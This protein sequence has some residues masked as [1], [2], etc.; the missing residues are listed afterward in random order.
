MVSGYK[1]FPSSSPVCLYTTLTADILTC[2]GRKRTG[3][4]TK[5]L[6]AAGQLGELVLGL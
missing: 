5:L 1:A 6:M 3:E 2:H 4:L